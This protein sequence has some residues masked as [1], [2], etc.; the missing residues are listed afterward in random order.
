MHTIRPL[1]LLAAGALAGGLLVG[2]G[3]ADASAPTPRALKP[4]TSYAM[5]IHQDGSVVAP[6]KGATIP[7]IDIV[8]STLRAYY[9]ATKGPNPDTAAGAPTTIYLPNLTDSPYT[10]NVQALEAQILA[11]LP[12]VAPAD[13]KAVVFDVDST[14][15]SDYANEEEMN[16]NYSADTNARW[17]NGGLFPA[18][19]GMPA[20]LAK[21][22]ANGYE[23]YAITGRPAS[24]EAATV[25]N[26]TK[27]GYTDNGTPTGT[28]LFSDGTIDN[29][30]TKDTANQPWV[31]CTLDGNSACSTVEY[32]AGTRR[33]L[34]EATPSLDVVL[35]VGDQWSDLEGGYADATVKIPNPSYFLPSADIPGAPA[36]DAAMVLPTTY[37]MK[38]DGSTGASAT[39]GDAL[40]NEGAVVSAIRAYY[41]APSSGAAKGIA[42]KTTS[43]YISEVTK[44]TKKWTKKL[45]PSC[46]TSA[47]RHQH[48]AVVFDVDDTTLWTYDMEDGAMG[49]AFDPA[50][51]NT[52][53]QD[54]KFAA[55]PS[56]VKLE[57]K[58]KKAGCTVVGLTGR[59]K[60][61]GKATLKNL[62]KVGYEGFTKHNFYFKP[63]AGKKFPAYLGCKACTTVQ[64]KAGT[65][66]YLENKRHFH[67]LA[68]LGDQYSDLKGGHAKKSVK[69]PNPT[70]YLP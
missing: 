43:P 41:N 68:N 46:R 63:N 44:L 42:D 51:Q 36:T 19:P 30:Y 21:I 52:W 24:Q 31:D 28:P 10:K 61:Q 6:T 48:P 13:N 4:P 18:V 67:I 40:P 65:R 15:L 20:L 38:A 37:R 50:L 8:K 34:E 11:K 53:V 35:N 2:A 55:V 47:R 3:S 12:A 22:K 1:A 17:V 14:L 54:K 5:T 23:L 39:D 29:V 16:F 70:Y 33:H 32:K 58:V 26:L 45:V 57:K 9:G 7:N 25:A 27:V 62:K 60:S 49:F 59:S 64:Y 66:K 56:M 69:L